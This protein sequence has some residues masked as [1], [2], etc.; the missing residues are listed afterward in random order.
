GVDTSIV[1][2]QNYTLDMVDNVPGNWNYLSGIKNTDFKVIANDANIEHDYYMEISSNG[3]S[4]VMR[5]NVI[6]NPKEG[7]FRITFAAKSDN[8]S[9]F[10]LQFSSNEWTSHLLYDN[11]ELTNQWKTYEFITDD[12]KSITAS[13]FYLLFNH[14]VELGNIQLDDIE[15]TLLNPDQQAPLSQQIVK[16]ENKSPSAAKI[17]IDPGNLSLDF[18]HFII[19]R[20]DTVIGQTKGYTYFDE[21]LVAKSSYTYQI[22]TVDLF[23]NTALSDKSSITT[24]NNNTINIRGK[25]VYL[26]GINIAI[27]NWVDNDFKPGKYRPDLWKEVYAN[28]ADAGGNATRHWLFYNPTYMNMTS[29]TLFHKITDAEIDNIEDLLEI[30]HDNGIYVNLTFLSFEMSYFDVYDFSRDKIINEDAGIQ[31]FIDSLMLPVVS[32]LYKHPALG[33]WEIMNE[34]EWAVG[35]SRTKISE[36]QMQRF[37]GKCAAAIHKIDKDAIVTTGCATSKYL[38]E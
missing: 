31:N 35:H 6:N 32:R 16:I 23:G 10:L 36:Y 34:P 21:E 7:Y 2:K 24:L 9:K 20:N 26:N 11:V 33:I 28:I 3:S 15:L 4:K 5:S 13:G 12:L 22:G 17:Y 18:S 14:N 1:I 38:L 30:A 29:D 25:D 8:V 27:K 37:I 19:Y